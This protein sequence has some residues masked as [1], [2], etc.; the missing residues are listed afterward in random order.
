MSVE[1]RLQEY[2]FE[3]LD[4]EVRAECE[5]ELERDPRLRAELERYQAL[6][7]LLAAAAHEEIEI[8]ESLEGR[9]RRSVLIRS[10]MA[11]VANMLEDT[12]GAYGRALIY[13]LGLG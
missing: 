7:A 6:Y 9:I 13:Y 10:Y 2:I 5:R 4:D 11:A 8:P 1:E 12:L 3:E